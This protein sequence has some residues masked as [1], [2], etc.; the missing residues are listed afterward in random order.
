MSL[1]E[2]RLRISK[3]LRWVHSDI[4]A[5]ESIK[6]IVEQEEEIFERFYPYAQ[7]DITYTNERDM[8]A[9]FLVDSIDVI[10]STRMLNTEETC[11]PVKASVCTKALCIMRPVRLP[12]SPI[13]M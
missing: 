11:L 4:L 12:L 8:F 13:E 3:A 2:E 5:D 7:L 6:D 9:Q 10:M 1:C